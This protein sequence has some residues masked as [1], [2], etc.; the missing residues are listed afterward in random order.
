MSEKKKQHIV[1]KVYLKWFCNNKWLLNFY[2]R[3]TWKYKEQKPENVWWIKHFYTIV[4]AEWEKDFTI[5][6]Y[7]SNEIENNIWDIFFKI[8]KYE[9]LS[10]DEKD[11]LA[12]FV[13]F[14]FLRTEV[15]REWV[16][17]DIKYMMEWQHSIIC[18]NDEKLKAHIKKY[19]SKTWNWHKD[20]RPILVSSYWICSRFIPAIQRTRRFIYSWCCYFL[21]FSAQHPSY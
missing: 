8:N 15:F 11:K 16:N 17:K 9:A 2:D 4:W 20:I 19:E 10:M 21:G 13:T 6:D 7:F 12:L 5:E 1:P 3:K 14:Q 18:S